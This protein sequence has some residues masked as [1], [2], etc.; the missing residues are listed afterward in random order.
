MAQ[1][2]IGLIIGAI[3]SILISAYFEYLHK[4]QISLERKDPDLNYYPDT[5]PAREGRFLNVWATNKPALLV[6]REIAPRTEVSVKFLTM[7]NKPIFRLRNE[8]KMG[9]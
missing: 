9:R 1:T 2:I 6:Q 4:P 3:I 5:S 7:D 8:G